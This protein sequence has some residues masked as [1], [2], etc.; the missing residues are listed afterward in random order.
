MTRYRCP[1]SFLIIS[2]WLLVSCSTGRLPKTASTPQ[3]P[4]NQAETILS[5]P[6]G[7]WTAYFFGYDVEK[8]RLSVA[9]FGN[10]TIWNVNQTNVGGEAFTPYRWS[11]D[12]RYLYFNIFVAIDGYVPFYQGAGLQRLD[13]LNGTVSEILSSGYVSDPTHHVYRWNFVP[14]SLSPDDKQL[15]YTN[16]SDNETQL[17]IRDIRTGNE[18]SLSFKEYSNAGSIIWSP[19]QDQIVLAVTKGTNWSNTLCSIELVEVDSLTSRTLVKDEDLVFDPIVWINKHTILLKER[20]GRYLYLDITTE[21][22]SP[23][24]NLITVSD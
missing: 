19:Q 14:F 17:V 6:D 23:A 22:L 21:K 4:L 13:V 2:F 20:G 24:P 1:K 5:S 3:L 10:T 9:N 8:F 12:S 7:N 15:A 16:N 18:R 11:Q